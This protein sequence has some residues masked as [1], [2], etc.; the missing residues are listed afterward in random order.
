MVANRLLLKSVF[1]SH[2]APFVSSSMESLHSI[3]ADYSD[4]IRT[5]ESNVRSILAATLV[6]QK[7]H[8]GNLIRHSQLY[9]DHLQC[10][11][12]P[13]CSVIYGK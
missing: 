7:F 13:N 12:L 11:S 9:Q 3:Y 2:S 6:S 1:R 5:M 8:C 10:Q 4:S